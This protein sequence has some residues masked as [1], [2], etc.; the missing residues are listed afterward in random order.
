ML[1]W[2]YGTVYGAPAHNPVNSPIIKSLISFK[3]CCLTCL[4]KVWQKM[5]LRISVRSGDPDISYFTD[6]SS[7]PNTPWW[8]NITHG[9]VRS[10]RGSKQSGVSM[11]KQANHF[12]WYKPKKVRKLIVI[13]P[14]KGNKAQDIA[15]VD[16]IVRL[17]CF[18]NNF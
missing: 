8:S 13:P 5:M 11:L 6:K 14:L 4:Q 16:K 12:H 17:R 7:P 15:F 9:D 3:W 2:G 10:S 1:L 18:W